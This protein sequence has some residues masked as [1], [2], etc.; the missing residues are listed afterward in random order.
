MN[1]R[2]GRQLTKSYRVYT[3][4]DALTP[5]CDATHHLEPFF[6]RIVFRVARGGVRTRIVDRLEAYRRPEGVSL[7]LKDH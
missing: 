4:N 5:A 2:E 1:R 3:E 7:L 6:E